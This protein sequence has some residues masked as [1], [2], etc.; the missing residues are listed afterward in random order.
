MEIFEAAKQGK[1]P[2]VERLLREI[3]RP[4]I[5]DRYLYTA[6]EVAAQYG[7]LGVVKGLRKWLLQQVFDELFNGALDADSDESAVQKVAAD[8]HRAYDMALHLA[9][10]HGHEAVVE[11]LLKAGADAE[12]SVLGKKTPFLW[13]CA[14]GAS[15][16]HLEVALR[17]LE[18]TQSEAM[19]DK[20]PDTGATGLHY[21]VSHEHMQM[22][23]MLLI[24]D[25]DP[26]IMDEEC[27]T[28]LD[29]ACE[30]GLQGAVEVLLEHQGVGALHMGDESDVFSTPLH[31][32]AKGGREDMVTFLLGKG[33][34]ANVQDYDGWTPL[35]TALRY[36]Q[37]GVVRL[38]LEHVGEGINLA[39]HDGETALH[40]VAGSS[41]CE[42]MV[43]LL[44]S[45][46]A[47]ATVEDSGGLT[48][49]LCVVREGAG[50]ALLVFAKHLGR[51]V[52]ETRDADGRTA[53]HYAGGPCGD[54]EGGR[55]LV[56]AGADYHAVDNEGHMPCL[57]VSHIN[58]VLRERG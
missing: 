46:G 21:A 36:G 42:G 25:A 28:P 17:L 40:F 1:L 49:L 4:E 23:E 18:H 56:Y 8:Y 58:Y 10:K 14:E 38:L 39:N 2:V 6:L 13:A 29:L 16:G 41:G 53:M 26:T 12:S 54:V 52:I 57:P 32:A 7:Q 15:Q 5:Q 19:G 35:M 37:E 27:R 9:S 31:H 22:L 33:A 48:P 34:D 44:L 55:A 47:D 50:K 30:R 43:D 3:S 51:H 45:K 11:V 24:L 20:H